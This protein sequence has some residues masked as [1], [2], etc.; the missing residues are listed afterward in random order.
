MLE[1]KLI[2]G[3]YIHLPTSVL[4]PVQ[5]LPGAFI[6]QP[7]KQM[8]LQESTSFANTKKSNMV[9]GM[10]NKA[11]RN[12]QLLDWYPL[13]ISQVPLYGLDVLTGPMSGCWLMIYRIDGQDYVG[14]VGTNGNAPPEHNQRV[15]EEWNAFAQ[16]NN[17]DVIAGF[18]PNHYWLNH[19]FPDMEQTDAYT[20][21]YGLLTNTYQLFSV[22]LYNQNHPL[23]QTLYRIAGVAEIQSAGLNQLVNI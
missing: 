17:V 11:H 9:G 21:I 20:F 10:G 13:A 16:Q 1:Q 12:F 6:N 4:V 5:Y 18:R 22:C 7:V 23:P 19:G 8:T 15:K 3:R 14:H 2:E